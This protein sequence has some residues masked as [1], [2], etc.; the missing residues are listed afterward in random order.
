MRKKKLTQVFAVTMAAVLAAS[1][2]NVMPVTVYAAEENTE[3][4]DSAGTEVEAG[5]FKAISSNVYDAEGGI[6]KWET[7]PKDVSSFGEFKYT[8]GLV[9]YIVLLIF[10]ACF[11]T[12]L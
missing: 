6:G 5:K 9:V 11:Y 7:A 10:F 3:T 4:G 12:S 1:T 8:L 2:P